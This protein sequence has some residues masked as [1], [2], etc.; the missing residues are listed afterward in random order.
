MAA[1]VRNGLVS[2]DR[3]GRRTWRWSL[4]QGGN[5]EYAAGRLADKHAAV[6]GDGPSHRGVAGMPEYRLYWLDGVD[7]IEGFDVIDAINDADALV[8]A[9]A[10]KKSVK[11]ELWDRDRLV[12]QIAAFIDDLP[13]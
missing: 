12:A 2:A 3:G 13:A 9:R 11:C 8:L 7:H 6:E 4:L 5:W 1:N 10:M